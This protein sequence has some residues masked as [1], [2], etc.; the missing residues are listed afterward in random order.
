[1]ISF[2][3]FCVQLASAPAGLSVTEMEIR[4][5][6]AL[7]PDTA[8][9][10]M[11]CYFRDPYITRY[12]VNGFIHT[13]QFSIKSFLLFF[14]FVW[15]T[16]SCKTNFFQF[17]WKILTGCRYIL[18]TQFALKPFNYLVVLIKLFSLVF[19]DRF[20]QLGDQTLFLNQRRLS[21]RWPLWKVGSGPV[22]LRSLKSES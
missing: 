5:F 16:E 6:Q 17:I 1:M 13:S 2:F 4:Q 12:A 22:M 19:S 8:H 9:Q 11:F 3:F 10:R 7:F 15:M 20:R 21:L 14:P 18:T